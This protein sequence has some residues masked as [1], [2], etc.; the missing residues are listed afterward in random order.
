MCLS[1]RPGLIFPRLKYCTFNM[2]VIFYVCDQLFVIC[3]WCL[4]FHSRILQNIKHK[5]L[6]L[7]HFNYFKC[8]G[9]I[10]KWSSSCVYAIVT[11]KPYKRKSWSHNVLEKQTFFFFQ[12]IITLWAQKYICPMYMYM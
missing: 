2:P 3:V 11:I 7:F 9:W 10:T 12:E 5:H 6:D 4:L 1:D 8:C